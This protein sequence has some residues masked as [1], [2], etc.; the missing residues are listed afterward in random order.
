MVLRG[1]DLAVAPGEVFGVLG[2]NGAGK[3]TLLKVLGNLVLPNEGHVHIGGHDL[4]REPRKAKPLIGYVVSE[5]RSFYWRLTGRENLRFFGALYNLRRAD[6]DTRVKALDDVL[7]LA[8]ALETRVQFYSTGMRQKLALARGLLNHPKV[9]LLD[10]PT[11]SL[12]PVTAQR[13]RRFLREELARGEGTTILVATHDLA[14]VQELCERVAVLNGGKVV[15]Q[16]SPSL[17]LRGRNGARE[18]TVTVDRPPR[19]V[20]GLLGAVPGVRQVAVRP[21]ADGDGLSAID[22][23]LEDATTHL[24]EVL[25]ALIRSGSRIAFCGPRQ[26]TLSDS[27]DAVVN[28]HGPHE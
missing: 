18:V 26:A 25:A 19:G 17:L 1:I 12:D 22:L 6:V 10:E 3:T 15:A 21:A 8:A 2:A 9:L 14:D 24:T 13:L 28:G 16:G 5:E 11:R 27:L 7:D 20:T 23:T 4:V